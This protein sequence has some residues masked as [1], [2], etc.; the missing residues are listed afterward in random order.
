MEGQEAVVNIHRAGQAWRFLVRFYKKPNG[1]L[2]I[3][4]AYTQRR[5]FR[6]AEDELRKALDSF[7]ILPR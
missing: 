3:I 5:G 7:R 6:R 1:P 2:Y 4:R